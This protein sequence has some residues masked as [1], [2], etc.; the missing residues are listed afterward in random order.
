[1]RNVAAKTATARN[2][3]R[4]QVRA[5]RPSRYQAPDGRDRASL[6]FVR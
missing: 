3:R 4:S 6:Q 2:T 5:G 1:V